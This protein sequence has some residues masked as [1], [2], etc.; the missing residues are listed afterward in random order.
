MKL[1]GPMA[2]DEKFLHCLRI[3]IVPAHFEAER[4][5]GIVDFCLKYGIGNVMLFINAEEYNVGHM[6]IEE[7][8][9]WV[10]TMKRAAEKLRENGITVSLNPWIE[11]GHLDRCRKLKPGQNFTTM[12][13]YDGNQCNMVV[14]PLCE[15]WKKYFFEFYRY[16]LSELEPDTV[17]VEDDFRL[18]NH[19]SLKYGGCFCDL[20]MKKYGEK[21]GHE[22]SREEFTDQLFRKEPNNEVRKVW[23]DVS[24]DTMTHLAEEIGKLVQEVHP[25]MKVGLMSSAHINHS[26]EARDW[27]GIHRGL[28]QG[29]VMIDRLHLPCYTEI[30]GKIYYFLFH[31]FPF[32]CRKFLPEECIVYPEL[33]N[34]AFGTFSKEARFLQFQVE[35]AIPLCIDGMTYDIFD[36]V[37]NGAIESFGYGQSIAKIT[38]YLNGVKKLN[39]QYPSL[40]GVVIPAD[41]NGVYHRKKIQ[42]FQD[43][44]PDEYY[45]GAYVGSVGVNTEVSCHKSFFGRTVLLSNGSVNN[46]TNDE[47]I[48]LFADNSVVLEGGA[49]VNL[50]DRGLG[51]LFNAESYELYPAE[52][53]EHSYEQVENGSAINGINGYRCSTH[54]RAG[55]YVKIR[56]DSNVRVQSSV[57]DFLGNKVGPGDVE[58]K[59]IFVIPY[60]IREILYEQYN[61]L[62]TTLLK[63]FLAEHAREKLVL[64]DHAGVY[65]FLYQQEEEERLI[66]VNSTEENFAAVNLR[67][68]HMTPTQIFH[69]DHESGERVETFFERNGDEYRISVAFPYLSTHTFLLRIGTEMHGRACH[70]RPTRLAGSNYVAGKL[71][72]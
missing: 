57:Y 50:L 63:N 71:L 10:D 51:Y 48:A 35:S 67:F 68:Y 7:A 43:F 6:T 42:N 58:I 62:R 39:L 27:Q 19:G 56:Y 22:I 54:G 28:A 26:M 31:M 20:H 72:L 18:H 12:V 40:H 59:N 49:A 55:T 24:R 13:D 64:T 8:R 41:P 44:Y 17:W 70:R 21:L 66:L 45:F 61:D 15:K 29:G 5:D 4:I 69:I 65:A 30:S 2:S 36:F 9:P 16:L 38:P 33:E 60:I 37:G 23:L 47:L 11:I 3:Q 25:G 32:V 46:F 1:R 34:G 52:E 14:C 53:R